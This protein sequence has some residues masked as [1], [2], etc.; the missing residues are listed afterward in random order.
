MRRPLQKNTEL[1]NLKRLDK[2]SA[3]D[4]ANFAL[5]VMR[6]GRAQDGRDIGCTGRIGV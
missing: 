6:A 3:L 4:L 2:R 5:A 1:L